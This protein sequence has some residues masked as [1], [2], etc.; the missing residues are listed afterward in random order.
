MIEVIE[1]NWPAVA[2]GLAVVLVL[3][4]FLVRGSS[5]PRER[6][7]A[8]D[9]LDEGA[10]PAQRNQAFID[11][12]SAVAVAKQAQEMPVAAP[13]PIPVPP[14]AEPAV[15]P[16]PLVA[17][18]KPARKK[19]APKPKA[20]P[21]AKAAPKAKAEPRSKAEPKPKAEPAP[22]P[23]VKT[24]PK[25]K[26][27]PA[28]GAQKATTKP[29]ATPK[30]KAQ[31]KPKAVAAPKPVPAP[32]PAPAPAPAPVLFASSG[33]DDLSRIKG[34]GPKLQALLP[35]LGVT[36]FAQIAAW[37]DADLG[38]IDSQLGVFAGRP[39]RD[40]WIEQAKLLAA[41][42]AAGFEAQFGKL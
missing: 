42:D 27:V 17:E 34:L 12:P 31:P 8:P 10:G 41:G 6:H 14:P 1:A 22:K 20:V 11:A 24:E 30:A 38:Q 5:K 3:L 29:K 39:Q 35:T 7:R 19:A 36:S 23:K 26:S 4:W 13:V 28:A 18:K 15:P 16:P 40:N 37:S 25:A 2:L 33:P 32:V 21:K 9:A